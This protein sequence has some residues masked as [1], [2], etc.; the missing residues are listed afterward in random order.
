MAVVVF[1][2]I[3]MDLVVQTPRLPAAG[4]TLTGHNFFTASGGKGANQAVAC[5][6]LGATT[7]M[8]GRVGDDLFGATLR[9]NLVTDGVDVSGVI[10]TYGY[11][12]GVAIIAV[13]DAAQ[14]TIIVVAGA[15][16]AIDSD[17]LAQLDIA[18]A[19]A[20]VLLLQLEIP[21]DN[22]IAAARR[23]RER[24]IT[25]VLDP[26]PAQ[27]LPSE[28]YDLVDIITPNET[29]TSMLVEFPIPDVEAAKRAAQV[30]LGRG[31][32]RVVIKMGAKGAYVDSGEIKEFLPAF[33][34]VAV[35]TVAAGDAFNGGLATALNDGRSFVE[36]IRWGLAAG[37]CS[38]TKTGAQPSLPRREEVVALLDTAA[39]GAHI[40]NK[41]QRTKN[42]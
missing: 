24:G 1:G 29:E 32:R 23:A 7:R 17:N 34:V 14:N 8:I 19:D 2:S 20:Q 15:N 16:G 25:V 6:R 39:S 22:V 13:D 42:T 3:N 38:V 33:S 41:E 40:E 11:P 4:E 35:D 5:A 27:R 10:T 31:A 28:L 18:L 12:S 36:A 26:A 9:D 30:L 37:A 21:L